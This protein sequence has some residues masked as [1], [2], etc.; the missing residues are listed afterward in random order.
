ML[1]IADEHRRAI[2]T[3]GEEGYP[4]EIC[5]FLIGA[6]SGETK[7][8][9]RTQ[10]I[11]NAWEEPDAQGTAA[12][13]VEWADTRAAS[14]EFV[15]ATRRRRFM[16]PPDEYYQADR[17]ARALRF[18][19][20]MLDA[21]RQ[22]QYAEIV[23]MLPSQ[24]TALRQMPDT[25]YVDFVNT[26]LANATLPLAQSE[27]GAAARA[28]QNALASVLSGQHTADDA[29]REVMLGLSS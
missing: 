5:G 22:R 19:N 27:S 12:K 23:H 8:V 28:M 6:W 1:Y 17:Q 26:L 15:Q 11:E 2:E 20:W 13:A 24:R 18:L 7:T 10:P 25:A 3:H 29:T 9:E 16:I 4:E 14:A 21:D